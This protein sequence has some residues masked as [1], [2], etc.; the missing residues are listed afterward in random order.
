MKSRTTR[1]SILLLILVSL[2]LWR[3]VREDEEKRCIISAL[4]TVS[5]FISDELYKSDC[6]VPEA[7]Q[8][9][10]RSEFERIRSYLA[11]GDEI[12]INPDPQAWADGDNVI[13]VYYIMW[14]DEERIIHGISAEPRMRTLDKGSALPEGLL[15]FPRTFPGSQAPTTAMTQPNGDKLSATRYDTRTQGHDT[16]TGQDLVSSNGVLRVPRGLIVPGWSAW[17][18]VTIRKH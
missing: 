15:V 14:D 12:W 17:N 13:V 1:L 7:I 2:V 5:S 11:P 10:S 16:G 9:M 8:R 18:D 4:R 6:S 3:W